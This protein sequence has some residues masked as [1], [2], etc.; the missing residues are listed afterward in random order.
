MR[1]FC[2]NNRDHLSP[3]RR[4]TLFEG[5]SVLYKIP[6]TLADATCPHRERGPTYQ[7]IP[8][9]VLAISCGQ[10]CLADQASAGP[11]CSKV[12]FDPIEPVAR[13]ALGTG[14]MVGM[15]RLRQTDHDG[16]PGRLRLKDPRPYAAAGGCVEIIL[17]ASLRMSSPPVVVPF[18]L[19]FRPGFR[20]L[21][22]VQVYPCCICGSFR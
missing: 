6:C 17:M 8:Q 13:T 18:F 7:D 20:A 21:S 3:I 9:H 14:E 15:L 12:A 5:L 1:K 11:D 19:R 2:S 16:A 10:R 4:S 22:K